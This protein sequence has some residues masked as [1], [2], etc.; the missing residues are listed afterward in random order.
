MGICNKKIPLIWTY[1]GVSM[2]G[3]D[4][5]RQSSQRRRR[6]LFA[7]PSFMD[8]HAT[9]PQL[10]LPQFTATWYSRWEIISTDELLRNNVAGAAV[11]IKLRAKV[12][13]LNLETLITSTV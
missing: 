2:L 8:S 3:L 6:I 13:K 10:W 12:Y 11:V 1:L 7:R 4:C 9:V 5:D